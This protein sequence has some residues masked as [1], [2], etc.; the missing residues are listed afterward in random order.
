MPN[1][2]LIHICFCLLT[3]RFLFLKILSVC[4]IFHTRL[5]LF[6]ATLH[7]GI[8]L[9][10]QQRMKAVVTGLLNHGSKSNSSSN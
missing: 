4:S 7:H 10:I 9:F 1:M 8:H 5:K 2:I 3:L 6:H